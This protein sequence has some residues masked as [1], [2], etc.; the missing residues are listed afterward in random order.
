[1]KDKMKGVVKYAAGP[2]NVELRE[3]DI[4]KLGPRDVLIAVRACTVDMTDVDIWRWKPPMGTPIT[5]E[6]APW[7]R[8]AWVK[9]PVILGAEIAGEVT[10]VGA[11]VKRVRIG[12]RVVVKYGLEPCGECPQCKLGRYDLCEAVVQVGRMTD[13][14]F[15]EYVKVPEAAAIRFP[16]NL[17]FEEAAPTEMVVTAFH[18]FWM[19]F[20][21]PG[22]VVVIMGP[23]V[24]GLF[25]TQ[26]AKELGAR[27]VILTGTEGDEKRLE[28]GKKLGADVIVNVTKESLFD[29]VMNET[30]DIGA[31]LVMDFTGNPSAINKA[32]DIVSVRGTIHCTGNPRTGIRGE[33]TIPW[34]A[35]NAKEIRITGS[36][37]WRATTD[38][39]LRVLNLMGQG[40]IKT[41]PL[42]GNKY[43]LE[44]W[45]EA[46]EARESK[47]E[48]LPIITPEL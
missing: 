48:L 23:G 1:V 25:A 17:T 6:E 16:D 47:R 4:P 33:V 21:R 9:I 26:L 34:I 29:I 45:Q 2:M 37:V 22:S 39:W 40:R 15:A 10:N 41:S 20:M 14:G 8:K 11:Q 30:N 18:S 28:L 27:K 13:G 5:R 42:L 32:F 36:K 43:P 19:T 3:V 31:D 24:V 35:I 12:D 44:K 46:F 7:M 38:E